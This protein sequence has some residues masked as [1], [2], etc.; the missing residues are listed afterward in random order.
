[1]DQYGDHLVTVQVWLR[2]SEGEKP[3]SGS[4]WVRDEYEEKRP[5]LVAGLAVDPRTIWIPDLE[6]E[7]RF[8]SRVEVQ[9]SGKP[10][11]GQKPIPATLL[12]T[13][14]KTP[15]WMVKTGD[16]IPGI[17]PLQFI[18]WEKGPGDLIT[19]GAAFGRGGRILSTGSVGGGYFGTGN[20]FWAQVAPGL[21]LVSRKLQPVGFTFTGKI[22]LEEAPDI[23]RGGEIAA[24]P[25]LEFSAF[26]R[27]KE[28][29]TR[30]A[31]PWVLTVRGFFRSE[32][33]LEDRMSRRYSYVRRRR[34]GSPN[35][36]LASGYLVTPNRIIVNHGLERE[37][38]MRL[39][40]IEI[41][42]GEK[43]HPA[44]FVGAFR[45]FRA[46][47]VELEGVTL[48]GPMDL[49]S[50]EPLR[51]SQPVIDVSADHSTGRRR[52][53]VGLNRITDYVQAY[54]GVVEPALQRFPRPG[55]LLLGVEDRKLLGVVLEVTRESQDEYQSSFRSSTGVD[56]RVL[57]PAEI[58][59]ILDRAEYDTRLT[60]CPADREKDMVWL[61][62]DYQSITRELARSQGVE[63]P[64]RGGEIGLMVLNVHAGSPAAR[65]GLAVGDVLLSIREEEEPDPLELRSRSESRESMF[66]EMMGEDV[67]DEMR[68]EMLASA[69][70]PWRSPR[71]F[72][73][74]RLTQIGVG[75]R[76]ELTYLRN[77]KER[78]C[79]ID[80]VL[81]PPDFESSPKYK[82]AGLGI[83]VK[84]LTHEV[85]AFYRLREDSPGVVVAKVERGSKAAI[86]KVLPYEILVS[87]NG[88]VLHQIDDFRE[89]LGEV[90]KTAPGERL[91]ELKLERMGK[92]RILRIR[93]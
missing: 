15:G 69:G 8:I 23:W 27:M 20:S 42:V 78:K 41:R 65:A 80:L 47:L 76:V 83:T 46:F 19:L 11:A 63:I 56:L 12:G 84:N 72:L 4:R 21:F 22:G 34:D 2:S 88:K 89:L 50:A 45:R 91:L 9:A 13:F 61:G 1:M 51:L 75:R 70:P 73:N 71:N 55:T 59:E 35:E 79:W 86:A 52:D 26:D 7:R 82:S 44:R 38:A 53:R 31:A 58:Q 64:T 30:K 92:S 5:V 25:V 66:L 77:G 32:E 40:R 37:N 33:D 67:P 18:P 28:A 17:Q 24:G 6:L 62:V 68:M 3:G 57:L 90:E 48:P 43:R 10:R 85:R 81:G 74:E 60:P 93:Y 14:L 29:I 54:R 16:P 39:E 49:S 87:A 36:F